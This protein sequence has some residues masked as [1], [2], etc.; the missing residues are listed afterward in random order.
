LNAAIHPAAATA[1]IVVADHER[2]LRLR[3]L[4]L[5]EISRS[6]LL[7]GAAIVALTSCQTGEEAAPQD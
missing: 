7:Q 5:Q 6:V 4:S 1:F 2:P 3:T